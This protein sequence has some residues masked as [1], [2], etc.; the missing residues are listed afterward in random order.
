MN[1]FINVDWNY[2]LLGNRGNE[3]HCF[4]IWWVPIKK[5]HSTNVNFI[6]KV[7]KETR[8]FSKDCRK[9]MW[10][11]MKDYWKKTY[12]KITE[13]KHEFQQKIAERKVQ[14]LSNDCANPSPHLLPTHTPVS[15]K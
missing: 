3:N 9:E 10:I 14:I 11:S 4:W 12:Q 1:D 5:D 6:E 7:W 2:D 15:S 8:I 13:K